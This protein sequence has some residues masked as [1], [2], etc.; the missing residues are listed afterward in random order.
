MEHEH[1][2][3]KVIRQAKASKS[4]IGLARLREAAENLRRPAAALP[5][6]R[7]NLVPEN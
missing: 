3:F 1:G 7:Q 6:Q 5:R 4:G 2:A